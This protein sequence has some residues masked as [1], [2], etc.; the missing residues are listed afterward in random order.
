LAHLWL[1]SFPSTNF[2]N[3]SLKIKVWHFISSLIP[4]YEE[5]Q[6]ILGKNQNRWES[7]NPDELMG[8]IGILYLLGMRIQ[9][10][11]LKKWPIFK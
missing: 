9:P 3:D 7:I 2:L 5:F 6:P 1:L 4:L 8:E 10:L 11:I